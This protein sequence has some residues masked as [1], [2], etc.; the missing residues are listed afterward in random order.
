M[1]LTRKQKNRIIN[2][3]TSAKSLIAYKRCHYVC[4]AVESTGYNE[5]DKS[6]TI[7]YVEEQIYPYYTVARWLLENHDIRLKN[8]QATEYRKQWIDHMIKELRK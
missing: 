3:L 7:T 8:N 1:K 5:K 2:V 6:L 4:N